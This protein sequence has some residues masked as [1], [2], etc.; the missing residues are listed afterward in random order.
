MNDGYKLDPISAFSMDRLQI[1]NNFE[2]GTS[3]TV[4][5]DYKLKKND[6]N[7]LDFSMAQI[8]NEKNNKNAL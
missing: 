1:F 3:G 2:T 7:K 5:F 4:G 8:L 6:I